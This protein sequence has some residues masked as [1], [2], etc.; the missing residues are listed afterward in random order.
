MKGVILHGG[1][2]SRLRPLTHTGPKQLILV[3]NKP[4]SQYVL[5]DL[6]EAGITKIAIVLGDIHPDKVKEYYGDGTRFGVKIS[7]INQGSPKGIAH[8]IGLCE[9]FVGQEPF[10]VYLGDNL[11]EQGIVDFAKDFENSKHDAA[12]LLAKVEDPTPYGVAELNEQGRVISLEEKPKIPKSNFVLVGTYFFTSCVFEV[13][14]K[15]KPSWRNELEITDAINKLLKSKKYKVKSYFVEG[16]WDDTGKPED[17]LNANMRILDRELKPANLGTV[18]NGAIIQG[19]VF[20]DE[21]SVVKKGSVI[22]GPVCIGRFCEIGPDTYIGPYTSIADHC[23]LKNSNIESSVILEG[24]KIECSL[25]I[26]DSLV[27]KDSQILSKHRVLPA[28]QRFIVG[29]KSYISLDSGGR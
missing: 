2:G 14:K 3:A 27:G 7:Y 23:I 4:I 13:I 26:Q 17:I 9:N 16:W 25:K 12:I 28:G 8:A 24:V 6:K 29:E 20:I 22:R 10:A 11:I 21:N 5:E 18:E 15:L 19:R 1:K